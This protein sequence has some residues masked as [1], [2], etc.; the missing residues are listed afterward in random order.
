[1]NVVTKKHK[2]KTL[3]VIYDVPCDSCANRTKC[4][5]ER[6]SCKAFTEYYNFGWFNIHQVGVRLKKLK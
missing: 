5:N 6:L 2:G 1:M 4:K 3:K